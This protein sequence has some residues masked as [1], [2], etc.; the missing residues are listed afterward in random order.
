MTD[1]QI[2]DYIVSN[3]L[4]DDDTTIQDTQTAHR[5]ELIAQ[6]DIKPGDKILEIGSGQGD[7]LAALAYAVGETGHVV[8]VDIAGADY[9]APFTLGQAIDYLKQSE[10]CSR[11]DAYFNRDILAGTEFLPIQHFDKVVFAHSSWYFDDIAQL[12]ATFAV[13]RELADTILYAEWD[14]EITDARQQNHYIAANVQGQL[15]AFMPEHEA[16]IRTLVTKHHI[17]QITDKL[18]LQLVN[19]GAI[20]STTM[21]DADWE[22][23]YVKYAFTLEKLVARGVTPVLAQFFVDQVALIHGAN[24]PLNTYWAVLK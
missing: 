1:K 12:A 24:V 11:V 8:G 7:M 21:Q 6:W 10:L 3:M 18:A 14:L 2:V 13:V 16:N 5:L 4:H 19:D 22:V 9:G 15:S 20:D 17:A 23:G